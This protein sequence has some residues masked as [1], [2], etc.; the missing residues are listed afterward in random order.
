MVQDARKFLVS[1]DY[2]MDLVAW[3]YSGEVAVQANAWS[4]INIPHGLPFKP[5]FFGLYS[6]DGGDTWVALDVEIEGGAALYSQADST[7]VTIEIHSRV[8]TTILYK[9]WAYAPF[10]ANAQVPT[11]S[12]ENDF[13]VNSDHDYLKLVKSGTWRAEVGMG[14][15]FYNHNLGY[16]PWV[17]I[18]LEMTDGTIQLPLFVRSEDSSI[19]PNRYISVD[20]TALR[21]NF[22]S[23]NIGSIGTLYQIHYRVYADE[24]GGT[25]V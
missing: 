15:G 14:I 7:N 6:I 22:T 23:L 12:S 9:L 8:T 4:T 25:D 2:P 3:S 20:N 21:A 10:G 17:M 13:R 24:I 18:W 5:L 16:K 19:D 1:S 11:P